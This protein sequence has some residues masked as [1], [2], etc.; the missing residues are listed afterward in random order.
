MLFFWKRQG[1]LEVDGVGCHIQIMSF[2]QPTYGY[3]EFVIPVYQAIFQ[4]R[5]QNNKNYYY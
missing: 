4:R 2:L 3:T 5:L 1:H